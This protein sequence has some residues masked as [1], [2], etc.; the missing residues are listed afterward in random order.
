MERLWAPWRLAYVA[1][2]SGDAPPCIFCHTSDKDRADLIVARG[3]LSF[4]IL[5]LFPY[6]N[7]HLMVVP[8]RHVPNLAAMDRDELTE[9]MQFTRRSEIVL[10]EAYQPPGINVG[11]NPGKPAGASAADPLPVTL[12]PR[13]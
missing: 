1:G 13:R 9:V 4:V 10:T 3:R 11:T 6:N 2:A 5:N 12:R 8:N 7:G